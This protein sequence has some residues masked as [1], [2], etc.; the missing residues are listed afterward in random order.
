MIESLGSSHPLASRLLPRSARW[1]KG[2]RLRPRR[3][4]AQLT[5]QVNSDDGAVRIYAA[6]AQTSAI[7]GGE[8]DPSGGSRAISAKQAW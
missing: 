6:T 5:S 4:D 2:I 8:P 7:S 1:G 3:W